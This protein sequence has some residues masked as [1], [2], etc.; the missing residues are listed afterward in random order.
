M[1]ARSVAVEL[2]GVDG[3]TD[4]GLDTWTKSLGVSQRE[5][6]SVVDL[7][8][9]KSGRVEVTDDIRLINLVPFYHP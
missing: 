7:C 1:R 2:G 8:L 6:T 4:R 3:H 5:D 9:D